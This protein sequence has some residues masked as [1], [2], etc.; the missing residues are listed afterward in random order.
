VFTDGPGII[1]NTGLP[2]TPRSGQWV[3]WMV[4][5]SGGLY[6]LSQS[7]T[8]PTSPHMYL[9]IFGQVRATEPCG[10]LPD[11]VAVEINNTQI[12]DQKLCTDFITSNWSSG[13]FDLS[14]YAGQTITIGFVGI[15]F[16]QSETN[17]MFI[18]DISLGVLP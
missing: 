6:S 14:A 10:L 9:Q 2:I 4:G 12:A 8:L 17:S 1:R 18:D 7:V 15:R 3:A 16:S 11:H 13:A 5:P